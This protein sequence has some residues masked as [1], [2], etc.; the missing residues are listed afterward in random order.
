MLNKFVFL[1]FSTLFVAIHVSP[2]FAGT[3]SWEQKY[4][5]E[6]SLDLLSERTVEL[7]KDWSSE[8][9]LHF[10]TK[11]QKED[12]KDIG[13]IPIDYD[14]SFQEVKDIGAFVTTPHDNKL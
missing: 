3:P 9:T 10:I 4:S 13:E 8:E 6:S 2:A 7:K 11:V 1:V 5:D 12:A 14:K